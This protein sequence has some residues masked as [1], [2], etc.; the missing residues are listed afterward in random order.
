[1]R[2]RL[3]G[4]T[5]SPRGVPS[6]GTLACLAL[7]ALILGFATADLVHAESR[8]PDM[9]PACRE[10]DAACRNARLNEQLARDRAAEPLQDQFNSR[11]WVYSF[12]I[13]A[14]VALSVAFRLRSRPRNEWIRIFTN[15]GVTGVWLGIGVVVLLL[16]TDGSS[17]APPPGPTLMV[18]VVLL[19][20]AAAGTLFGRSEGWAEQDPSGGI[21]GMFVQAG[22]RVIDIG[23]AGQIRRSRMEELASWLSLITV[24][25]TALTCLFA[26]VFVLAQPGC[27]ASAS[28]PGWTNPIDSVAAV[29]AIGAM[30]AAVGALLLRRWIAALVG[31]VICPVA[32]LFVLASTCAFY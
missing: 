26:F 9:G 32:V 15:L 14:I 21:R 7:C 10:S 24:G 11:A 23:T 31:L 1:M 18:P 17:M 3:K 2:E 19:V 22:K 28:P 20:A 8:L 13:L 30:A 16:A 4:L 27:D 25:L 5:G 29:T 12:A 6:P